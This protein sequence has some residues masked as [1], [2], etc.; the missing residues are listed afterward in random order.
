MNKTAAY[1]DC[2]GYTLVELMV[3][4]SIIATL[5][6]ASISNF[7]ANLPRYKLRQAVTSILSTLQS[8]RLRAVKENNYAVIDFDPD[9]NGRL[10]G[11]YIAF[12]DNGSGVLGDWNWQPELGEPL[13]A[14]GRL[15]DGVQITRTS[16]SK[17]RLRFNSQGHLMGINRCIYLKNSDDKTKKITVYASGN[18]RAF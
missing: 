8:A 5:A 12:V 17:N 11:D 4:L 14:K 16:F 6:V 9:G 15:P 2:F 1:Q 13:I 18:S 3:V 7:C 10:D